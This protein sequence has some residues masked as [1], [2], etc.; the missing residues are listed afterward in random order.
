MHLDAL[1]VLA[2]P[3]VQVVGRNLKLK[4]YFKFESGTSYSK[5]G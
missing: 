5:M 3:R 2:A 1:R 4:A